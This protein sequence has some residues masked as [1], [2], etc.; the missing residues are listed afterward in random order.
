MIRTVVTAIA[1]VAFSSVASLGAEAP[2]PGGTLRIAAQRDL[3][4]LNPFLRTISFDHN[5]RTLI[6]EALVTESDYS[7]RPGLA[8]SWEISKDGKEYTFHLRRSV[9]F[10]DGKTMT[11]EDVRWSLEHARDPRSR[12]YGRASLP[13]KIGRASCR[14]RV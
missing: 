10:H 13:D 11:S 4:T 5:L 9:V 6:Y 7:V 12:A 2:I 1:L 14:E 8:Q 3:S